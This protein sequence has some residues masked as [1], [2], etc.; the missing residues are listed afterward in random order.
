M[1]FLEAVKKCL[2]GYVDF[3]GRA[4]RSEYWWFFVFLIGVSFFFT[5]F[6]PQGGLTL[7]GLFLLGMYPPYLAVTVRRFHD[8]GRS[9]WWLLSGLFP[10]IGVPIL[11]YFTIIKGT[12]GP[13]DWGP[14]PV[15]RSGPKF[16]RPPDL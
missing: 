5:F 11:L 16:K 3:Q 4:P 1:S 7:I 14:D 10:P 2:I 15:P 8:V 6:V 13:N 9:G 12:E